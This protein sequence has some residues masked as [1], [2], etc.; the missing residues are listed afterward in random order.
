[1]SEDS[2]M[3]EILLRRQSHFKRNQSKY[4]HKL[5]RE[6]GRFDESENENFGIAETRN[7]SVKVQLKSGESLI[8]KASETPDNSISKWKYIEKTDVPI[9][10]SQ[11]WQLAFKEGEPELP[12]SRTLTKLQ[13]WTNFTE[14]ASTQSFSGTG[15]YTT[16][17]NL[18][19]TSRRLSI[20]I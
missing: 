11:P 5:Y 15:I 17:L 16:T 20:E 7:N 9:V 2:L 19:E 10:L 1:M 18:K 12:K 14:D 6:T 13:P 8:I 3:A 4:S